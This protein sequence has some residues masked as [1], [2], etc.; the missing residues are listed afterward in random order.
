MLD[1]IRDRIAEVDEIDATYVA[2]NARYADAF[3]R[4]A[5]E[6]PDVHIVDDGTTSN[7]D[8]LGAI[9]DIRLTIEREA[10]DDDLMVIA[11]DNLIEFSLQSFV[12][13]VQPRGSAVCLKDLK[14]KKKVSLYGMVEV[15]K[16]GKIID[17]EEKPPKPRS[18]LISI[19]VYYFGKSHLPLFRQY[20]EEG[21]SKDA[22]GFY[23]QWFHQQVDVYGHVVDGEWYDIGDIDSYNAANEIIMK[24]KE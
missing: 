24:G 21:H 10:I 19:G 23:L 17:F 22:P 5:A 8:R 14:S 9:G 3:E 6:E 15:N 16:Q 2:T 11:G 13:D 1:W 7:E 20:L 18:T 12:E 4:W